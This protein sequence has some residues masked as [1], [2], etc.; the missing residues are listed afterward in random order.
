MPGE[1]FGAPGYAR[2]S[3]AL[4]DDD[5]GEG[6]GRIADLLGR[7]RPV[8]RPAA[9][10]P[11]GSWPSPITA[12]ALVEGAGVGQRAAGR[13]RR[14]LV[15]RGPSRARA[16]ARSWS[17]GAADGEPPTTS[18]P[19]GVERPHPGA[20][21]RRRRVV[22]ARRRAVV[23]RLG[24]P[25]PLPA[26]RRRR[27]G[28]PQPLTPEPAVAA[29]PALRRRR[30]Q[31]GRRLA[32]LRPRARTTPTA[33]E[34][35]NE[36][37]ALPARPARTSASRSSV[38][39]VTGPDFVSSPR[40]QP[41]RRRV[42]LAPV[43]PPG[44]AVGRH[45]AALGRRS[46]PRAARADGRRAG[47]GRPDESVV[48]PTWAARRLA[49][50]F[51]V[52]PH[53]LV[54]PLP[55]VTGGD[56]GSTSPRRSTP[57]DAEIGGPQWVFGQS[58]LRAA[59]RRHAWS[60]RSA[61]D[62]LDRLGVVEPGTAGSSGSTTPYTAVDQVVRGRRRPSVV[63]RRGRRPP[64]SH[65][66]CAAAF[67][68]DGRRVE[69]TV[70]APAARPRA[71]RRPMVLRARADHVPDRRRRAPPT[72]CYYPPTNPEVVGPAGRAAA[73]ARADPRRSDRGGPADAQPRHAST[74]P[75]AASRWSTST[76]AARP[77]TA[78]PYRELLDGTVGRRRRRGLRR[79]APSTSPTEGDVDPERLAIRGGS[80]GGYTTLA[81]LAFHDAFA[82]RRQPLRRRRP[83]GAGRATPTSSRAATS[84]ASS[85]RTREAEPSTRR[86]R[87]STTPTG[88]SCPL[89][90]FQG[91]EDQVV[92]PNQ[93][94]MIV[95]ALAAKGVPVAYLAFEGEQHGFRQA[96]NIVRALE[97][98]LWFYGQ[99]FG[100]DPGRRD[101]PP[102]H[103][104]EPIW[105]CGPP[106]TLRHDAP[107]GEPDRRPGHDGRMARV[108]VT[109]KIADGG[110][111][112]LRPAGH[113]VDVQ[114][115]AVPRGAA[116]PRCRAPHALII[117]SATTVTAE[118]LDAGTDLVV[119]GRAGIGLDNVDVE[120]RHRA[121]RDGGQRAAVEH[122][123]GRR[124]H[125][126]DAAG[127][128]PATSP[129]PTPR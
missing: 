36:I 62:G 64:T 47:G 29:R 79:R 46:T 102:V 24:R 76:T 39:L 43:G 40:G 77:A 52:R 90:V 75:A 71:R 100:F 12:S 50:W 1:A 122:A 54:E 17:G 60:C 69:P 118:V 41:R 37:V 59:A 9:D 45:R 114:H 19:D 63:V 44:H 51:V 82:R 81:A 87:R 58:L 13:R 115:R 78:A 23:R 99:V 112:R 22:G 106:G 18:L 55:L 42:W 111:E 34:A 48:Q 5:L 2:L 10:P 27:S 120:A 110:L 28:D 49:C 96:A 129:R 85:A 15:V 56:L 31:P 26:R 66:A 101:R 68:A 86:A 6:V 126:G 94:E 14:R 116:R 53:R 35:V 32:G 21:V 33:R 108:L 25:A 121:G 73:A 61:R 7:G 92:P 93:A 3:F 113:D 128:R 83:R 117:R 91:L 80:A 105:R 104:R 65:A 127:R 97:A 95:D 88:S 70:L 109:E 38:V 74:G 84:T 67:A 123:L 16:A 98:E 11:Y 20:R 125:D 124:A 4:G 57:V 30:R 119:V 8:S 107:A 72:R 103:R 89:I